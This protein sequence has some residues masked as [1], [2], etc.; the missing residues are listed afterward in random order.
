VFF[1]DDNEPRRRVKFTNGTPPAPPPPPDFD[2]MNLKLKQL[3]WNR[4]ARARAARRSKGR[5]LKQYSHNQHL[6]S[7]AIHRQPAPTDPNVE[8]WALYSPMREEAL[9]MQKDP[10]ISHLFNPNALNGYV[11][12][13]KRHAPSI[14]SGMN[15]IVQYIPV[16]GGITY[17]RKDSYAAVWGFDTAHCNSNDYPIDKIEWI[18]NECNNLLLGLLLAEKLWPEFKQATNERKAQIADELLNITDP[19]APLTDKLGFNALLNTLFGRIGG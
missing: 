13:L 3:M 12:F 1:D 8:F 7:L 11:V 2:A 4:E 18:M 17:A 14:P 6:G 19:G 5:L 15:N 10:R 9:R 16:H